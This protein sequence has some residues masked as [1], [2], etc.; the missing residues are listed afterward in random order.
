MWWI[1]A[2]V[3]F[4]IA[5]PTL[6]GWI[7]YRIER[8]QNIVLFP[9]EWISNPQWPRA[10]P[11]VLVGDKLVDFVPRMQQYTKTAEMVITLASASN[12][13]IPG[14]V[15]RNPATD[16]PLVLLG[17]AVVWGVCFIAWMSYCY[18]QALY[19]IGSFQAQEYS[20]MFALGF[21][22]LDCFAVA[23]LVLALVIAHALA[24]GQALAP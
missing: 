17:F 12:V 9:R 11:Y 7:H 8:G 23:Y 13:F 19:D 20:T 2:G 15:S 22:A 14:H 4:G 16:L 1:V 24:Y 3:L 18:E 5:A 6:L 10:E 21:G